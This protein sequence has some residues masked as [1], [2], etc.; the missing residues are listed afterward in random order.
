M[1]MTNAPSSPPPTYIAI[2]NG[3]RYPGLAR[4]E[5]VK[6]VMDG[7]F[8]ESASIQIEGSSDWIPVCAI[9]PEIIKKTPPA[10]VSMASASYPAPF[11]D[12]LWAFLLDTVFVGVPLGILFSVGSLIS[13]YVAADHSA[14]GG[15]MWLSLLAGTAGIWACYPI[16]TLASSMQ[17]TFGMRLRSLQLV[18]KNG[19][20]PTL[21]IT[22]DR[23]TISIFV[24][25][26]CFVGFAWALFDPQCRTLHDLIAGTQVV[27]TADKEA[28]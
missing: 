18:T 19:D 25:S 16:Y 17:A 5:I 20:R 4:S 13:I 2:D 1:I 11:I 14:I 27:K 22:S 28:S 3:A 12:R 26:F 6:H 10:P 23:T 8:S 24:S 9:F 21:K 15:V 7:A